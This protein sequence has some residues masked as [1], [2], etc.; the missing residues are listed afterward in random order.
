MQVSD[1]SWLQFLSIPEVLEYEKVF[2]V[3]GNHEYYAARAADGKPVKTPMA[4]VAARARAQLATL[5]APARDRVHLLD[6]C[7]G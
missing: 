7:A 4:D 1:G 6:R 3:F 5:P 2:I